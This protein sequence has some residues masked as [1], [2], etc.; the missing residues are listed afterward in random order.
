MI[1]H[2]VVLRRLVVVDAHDI[3]PA[4]RRIVLA[5][6]Q[7]GAIERDGIACPPFVTAAPDDHVKIFPPAGPAGALPRQLA[8]RLDWEVDPTPV[9]R[10]YTV[11]SFADARVVV[12]VAVDHDGP[13]AVWARAARPGDTVH[14]AGPRISIEHPLDAAG[15]LL[16]GDEAALPAIAR[17][18][19]ELPPAV[20]KRALIAVSDPATR[21]YPVGLGDVQWFVRTGPADEPAALLDAAA[22]AIARR[23]DDYV[24][25]A[26]EFQT[27]RRLRAVLRAAGVPRRRTHVTH[28]WAQH[29]DET[30]GIAV[31]ERQQRLADHDRLFGLADLGAPL[32]IRAAATLRLADLIDAGA[33]TV[34]QLAAALHAD[35]GAVATLVGAL[36]ALG[37]LAVHDTGQ[38]EQPIVAGT[39][40]DDTATDGTPSPAAPP[41]AVVRGTA[42]EPAA[43][44]LT[45]V[46]ELLLSSDHG[47][48]RQRLDLGDRRSLRARDEALDHS[49]AV[50]LGEPPLSF[51]HGRKH[52]D[53]TPPVAERQATPP[54]PT[55]AG[56]PSD[57]G[58]TKGTP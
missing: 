51:C 10:D 32:A 41:D 15:Y 49:L 4:L 46:G 36:D 20:P 52:D 58:A 7:L 48:F 22:E 25:A 17:F 3:V 2:P 47:G 12:D 18:A 26:T 50:L 8:G 29:T 55:P 40:P 6:D 16:I 57:T 53:G 35:A 54:T 56:R 19:E 45:S 11:R 33:Q 44:R 9:A 24:W 30:I 31:A 28:Y 23:P 27:A 39:E 21:S 42:A 43:Y 38:P 14:I 1:E 13:G 37:L 5:G 34:E